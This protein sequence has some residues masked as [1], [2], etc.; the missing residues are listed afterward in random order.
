MPASNQDAS[1]V[2]EA[3]NR[4]SSAMEQVQASYE[5]SQRANR[6]LR[7]AVLFLLV[8]LGVA[9]YQALS[10]LADVLAQL[11]RIVERL[12]PPVMDA[13][14]AEARRKE[15]LAM[16]PPE[17]RAE[18]ERFEEERK[19]LSDYLAAHPDFDP[20]ATVALFLFQMAQS[21]Q[22][23]PDMYRKVEV[24]P[25][26]VESMEREMRTMN[27]KVNALPVL[28]GD[29]QGM[30]AKMNALPALATEV[31]AMNVKM[32]VM[33]A[34]MDSTMGRTGRMMPWAW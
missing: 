1:Q 27:I 33:A 22:V 14:A 5:A 16:L 13:E 3:L 29:V 2:A 21:V 19:W 11:P 26:A 20:G 31:Q 28:A 8:I 25:E 30:N 17:G 4:L 24:M 10:P 15:L 7:I 34:G 32:S 6:R 12:R 9:T 23:M 18:V